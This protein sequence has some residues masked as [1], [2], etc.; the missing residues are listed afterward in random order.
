MIRIV[1]RL[2]QPTFDRTIGA[3]IENIVAGLKT[4]GPKAA[5]LAVAK[6]QDTVADRF[7]D[8][9]PPQWHELAIYTQEDRERQGYGPKEP[10]LRRTGELMRSIIDQSH[11]LNVVR[12][13]T[14]KHRTVGVLGTDD[15]RA[16]WLQ[17][18]TDPPAGADEGGIPARWMWPPGGGELEI[19]MITAIEKELIFELLEQIQAT[20]NK[21]LSDDS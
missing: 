21:G 18:G 12:I 2:D 19:S 8:E 17:W 5:E 4:F 15:P 14:Y 20:V 10:I 11:D 16:S 6:V 1:L 3:V 7:L 9:G 13:R